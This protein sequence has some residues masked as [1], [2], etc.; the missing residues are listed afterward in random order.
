MVKISPTARPTVSA[1]RRPVWNENGQGL[2]LG[3]RDAPGPR[4]V[5]NRFRCSRRFARF[6]TS[7]PVDAILLARKSRA[8]GVLSFRLRACSL[9]H[10]NDSS[11]NVLR[12]PN[13]IP[14]RWILLVIR[15]SIDAAHA[16]GNPQ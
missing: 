1:V 4:S 12:E 2:L 7:G 11:P 9:I 15:S 8:Y 13:Y 3:D 10:T 6:T 14:S 5:A 16:E